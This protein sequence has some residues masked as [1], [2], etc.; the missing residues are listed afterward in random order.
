MAK[1]GT[2]CAT[3]AVWWRTLSAWSLQSIV[4]VIADGATA[5]G[6]LRAARPEGSAEREGG[7]EHD[8]Q[9]EQW[10]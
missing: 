8:Q 4:T 5:E 7:R 10:P 2:N 9:E 6:R 1:T 3:T